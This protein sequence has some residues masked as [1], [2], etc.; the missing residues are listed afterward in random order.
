MKNFMKQNEISNKQE[1]E[2]VKQMMY[3]PKTKSEVNDK[4]LKIDEYEIF[5]K[6]KE[7]EFHNII[8][9]FR[10]SNAK[11]LKS[12]LVDDQIN[13]L[14]TMTRDNYKN[15]IDCWEIYKKYYVTD[16]E[17][18]LIRFNQEFIRLRSQE[19]SSDSKRLVENIVKSLGL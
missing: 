16:D 17:K 7:N 6:N 10:R 12:K 14:E 18:Y 9:A 13:K 2:Y 5:L 11:Y 19:N 3:K 15:S 1:I 4:I 8:D